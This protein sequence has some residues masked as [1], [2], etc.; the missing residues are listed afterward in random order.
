[1]HFSAAI[2][3]LL[4]GAV[5]LVIVAPHLARGDFLA[6]G[7]AGVT[8]LFTLGWLTLTIFGA[9]SQLLPVAL[10]APLYSVRLGHAA[11]W[12]LAPGI[13]LFA[14][15]VAFTVTPLLAGGVVLV[16]TGIVLQ[17][18]NVA[19]TLSRGRT[20]DVTWGG[21]AAGIT[22]LASTLVLGMTLAH[23]LHSGFIA[24]ARIRVLAAHL[25][26][27]L[28]GWALV[29]I[30]GVANR[31]LPMFLLAHGARTQW[32][33]R[34]LAL[35]CA[36]VPLLAAG[37]LGGWT[38]VAWAGAIAVEAGLAS[39]LWQAFAFYRARMRR[40]L[41]P[42]MRFARASVAYF[43]LAA[44]LGP[45]VLALG[46]AHPRLGES[47]VVSALLGALVLF[48]TGFLYKI[49]PLLVWT[50]RFGGRIGQTALPTA[51]DL[52]SA[53]VARVQLAVNASAVA[54]LLAGIAAGSALV[55]RGGALLFLLGVTLFAY[56]MVRVRWA[57]PAA[58]SGTGPGRAAPSVQP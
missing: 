16:A 32:S 43:L 34:A 5:G 21:I 52:Y 57:T 30:V 39:F 44:A 23:N 53:P 41:D 1:E 9:L 26:V 42:G 10:G 24:A 31:L 55:A 45:V 40:H 29:V 13:A 56:Q 37:L 47:Y 6:P 36:G 15:G 46:V 48:V 7:V 35:L 20:R 38:I 22:F 49:V 14:A 11:F 4:M 25:H 19:V 33:R 12:T 3:Y 2:L 51:A 17:V 54:V 50:A 8:H 28:V 27:A 58:F 18:V